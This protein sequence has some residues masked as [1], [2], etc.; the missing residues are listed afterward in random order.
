MCMWI[1]AIPNYSTIFYIFQFSNE[2]KYAIEKQSKR[3]ITFDGYV[4][5]AVLTIA[6]ALNRSI[7]KLSKGNC[8]KKTF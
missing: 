4:Y 6:I 1:N 8:T 3:N 7:Q 2:V 5:D